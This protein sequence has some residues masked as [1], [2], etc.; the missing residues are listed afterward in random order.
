M[1]EMSAKAASNAVWQMRETTRLCPP[2]VVEIPSRTRFLGS[3]PVPSGQVGQISGLAADDRYVYATYNRSFVDDPHASPA[4]GELVVLDHGLLTD[5]GADPVVT[6]L[7][8]G[9]QPRSVAVNPVTGKVYVLNGGQQG[10][11]PFSLFV[12]RRAGAGFVV[13]ARI[14]LGIGLFDVAVNP[15]TNRVYVSN[16]MQVVPGSAVTGKIHVIDGAND[17]ELTGKAIAVERPMGIVFDAASDTLFAALSHVTEPVI[18]AVAAI[19]CGADGSTHTVQKIVPVPDGSRPYA[20]AVV[21]GA[22]VHRLYL[23]SM[24]STPTGPVPPNLTRFELGDGSY[25]ARSVNSAFGGPVA[26]STDLGA[27]HV[28][29]TTNAGFQVYDVERETMSPPKSF[30]PFPVSVA[31]D[32]TGRVHVGDGRDGTLTTVLPVVT[33]GPIGEHWTELG[34]AGHLGQPVTGYRPL[35]GADPRAGYQVF[36]QGAVFASTDRGAVVLSRDLTAAWEAQATRSH[37][38]GGTVQGYLGA[39]VEPAGPGS[40]SASFQRGM[41]FRSAPAALPESAAGFAVVGEIHACYA[42]AAHSFELGAP[43]E[44]EQA[45]PDGGLRQRFEKGEICWRADVGAHAVYTYIWDWWGP[46][47]PANPLGYPKSDIDAFVDTYETDDGPVARTWHSCQFEHGTIYWM[48]GSEQAYVVGGEILKAYENDFGGPKGKLGRPRGDQTPTPTSGGTYQDFEKGVVVWHPPGHQYEGARMFRSAQL[49]FT[50]F[51]LRD[52]NDGPLGG[53]LDLWVR[54]VAERASTPGGQG[55]NLM[56]RKYPEDGD[57]DSSDHTFDEAQVVDLAG[58]LR[59]SDEFQ[60]MF[61]GYDAD[62][63]SADDRMGAVNFGLV[64]PPWND[65]P[66]NWDVR[67]AFSVDNLWGLE[68]PQADH[69]QHHFIVTLNITE[70]PEDYD[71]D[72]AFRQQWWWR[73]NNFITSRLSLEQYAATFADVGSS[74]SWWHINPLD[75]VDE[76]FEALYYHLFYKSICEPGNCFGMSLEAIYAMK[77]L[78]MFTEPIYRLGHPQPDSAGSHAG[79]PDPTDDADLIGQF[80]LKHGYQLGHAVV[81]WF[82]RQFGQGL[83]HNPKE[84]FKRSKEAYERGDRPILNF[85]KSFKTKAHTVLPTDWVGG[86]DSPDTPFEHWG[87]MWIADPKHEWERDGTPDSPDRFKVI[88]HNDNTFEY[89]GRWQGGTLLGDRMFYI[90]WDLVSRVPTLPSWHVLMELEKGLLA[91]VVGDGIAEQITDGAGRTLFQ[92]GLGHPPGDWSDLVTDAN[93]RIPDMVPVPTGGDEN[94]PPQAGRPL[95]YGRGG[96]VTHTY[97]VTGGGGTYRWALR[98]PAMAA[99]VTAASGPVAD[100][101]TGSRLGT[102][103]RAI[104]FAVPPGGAAKTVSLVLDAMPRSPRTRQFLIDGLTVAPK[105]RVTSTLRDGGR[106]LLI[107]NTGPA[108]SLRLRMRAAPGEAPTSPRQVPLAAGKTTRLRPADWTPGGIGTAPIRVQ[109]RDTLDGPPVSCF[110]V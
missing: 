60:I 68:D 54:A 50:G 109:V 33:T 55:V 23:A 3:E 28:Y 56:N 63:T 90:P 89:D 72:L 98:T 103:E 9:Y 82:L 94:D 74:S 5:P 1:N 84:V 69:Q 37:P 30:G 62:D 66:Y 78:S 104:A 41:V 14:S 107:T 67:P 47:G 36:E 32:A 58:P 110:E 96:D 15:R 27:R 81:G 70:K 91:F 2:P 49:R 38:A 17:V 76:G 4:A 6:R 106:E 34:G 8:M 75:Y 11:S 46:N 35:P 12:I 7:P 13:S 21:A 61:A 52:E 26:L 43:I 71:P 93:Q 80:N 31:V 97:S 88:I 42:R 45:L 10:D 79:E 87:E 77:G 19:T 20:V 85:S 48:R 51:R 101:I 40:A 65:D 44:N 92:P 57:Y 29:V 25:R 99:V 16:W 18:D 95:F 39:P 64:H 100:L 102:P 22:G 108:T 53:D 86:D 59:G 73:V 105:Q 24:G 83:T